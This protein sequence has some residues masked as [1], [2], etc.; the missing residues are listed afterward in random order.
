MPPAARSGDRAP[1][2]VVRA[3][4]PGVTPGEGARGDG[5]LVPGCDFDRNRVSGGD[6]GL[7]RGRTLA[8]SPAVVNECRSPLALF[9]H[10]DHPVRPTAVSR[11]RACPVRRTLALLRVTSEQARRHRGARSRGHRSDLRAEARIER[12][13]H[14][15]TRRRRARA[16]RRARRDP[17]AAP[18]E[19]GGDAAL[20]RG[21]RAGRRRP[22]RAR[23][24]RP[25]AQRAARR[26]HRGTGL[27]ADVGAR[28]ERARR[29][30]AAALRRGARAALGCGAR[31]RTT[32]RSAQCASPATR[33]RRC[34]IAWTSSGWP[35]S[36]TA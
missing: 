31:G 29:L 26:G 19:E 1:P 23:S 16:P 3:L 5:A 28:A 4:V 27:G 11:W 35:N 10:S 30:R 25:A 6:L 32:R 2:S 12:R 7:H 21:R 9:S 8:D 20:P 34:T 18:C 17:D 22:R 13:S 36:R 24:A 14:R 15:R 33:W